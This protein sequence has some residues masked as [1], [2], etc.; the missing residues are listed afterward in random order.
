MLVSLAENI[1]DTKLDELNVSLDGPKALHDQIRGMKGLFDE[2]MLGLKK[3]NHFKTQKNQKKPFI[4]LQCT[5]SKYNYQYLDQLISVAE[6]AKANSLTFHNLIFLNRNL[7]ERQ[8]EYDKLLGCTSADW[9]GFIFEPEIEGKL[10][11]KKIK[12]IMGGKYH[13]SVDFYPKFSYSALQKYYNPS[14]EPKEYASNCLSPWMAAYVFP[15]GEVRPCLNFDYS[16][17]NI[18]KGFIKLWNNERALNFRRLLK[19]CQIFP[20][21]ARCTEL[22]RY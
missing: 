9:E 6:E 18:T 13:F 21:C 5:I 3:I 1:I 12:Q 4:N 11:Y 17:G 7:L 8:K 14:Y 16:Y 20:V 2:I 19:R 10:L 22:Y 15:D